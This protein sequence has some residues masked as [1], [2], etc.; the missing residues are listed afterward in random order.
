MDDVERH[1]A[2][3]VVLL[4]GAAGAVLVEYAL[5]HLQDT[6]G[7]IGLRSVVIMILIY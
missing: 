6:G 7:I 1:H 3:R 4:D 5:R 2:Q